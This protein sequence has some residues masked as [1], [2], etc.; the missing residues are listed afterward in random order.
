MYAWLWLQ[1][2]ERHG[3]FEAQQKLEDLHRTEE[4][5]LYRQ[6]F[7]ER[8]RHIKVLDDMLN[9]ERERKV[10]E[11]IAWFERKKAGDKQRKAAIHKVSAC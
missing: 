4:D 5:Q 3:I 8:Q 6:M 10:Q 11:L 1:D 9:A 7:S 2:F